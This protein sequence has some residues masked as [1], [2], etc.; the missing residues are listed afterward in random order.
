MNVQC[1]RCGSYNTEVTK[2]ENNGNHGSV[3][4]N[5]IIITDYDCFDCQG[6]GTIEC[7]NCG[8]LRDFKGVDCPQC[9]SEQV[10]TR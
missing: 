6:T 7:S 1:Q 10:K 4:P 5:E 2:T 3:G 9:G 8:E